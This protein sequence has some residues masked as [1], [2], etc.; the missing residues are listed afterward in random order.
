[1]CAPIA[2]SPTKPTVRSADTPR[3]LGHQQPLAIVGVLTT[4]FYLLATLRRFHANSPL[5]PGASGNA[6]RTA[7]ERQRTG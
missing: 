2:P 1:M 7:A 6:P 4:Q 3:V 5:V